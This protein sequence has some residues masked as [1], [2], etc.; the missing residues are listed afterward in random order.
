MIE[1][2]PVRPVRPLKPGQARCADAIGTDLMRSGRVL[3]RSKYRFERTMVPP[4]SC[5]ANSTRCPGG[6]IDSC[7]GL[8]GSLWVHMARLGDFSQSLCRPSQ[9]TT[10]GFAAVN[11]LQ[12][13]HV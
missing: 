10:I 6:G 9:Q 13:T 12:R 5:F 3:R 7:N 11:E 8:F 1:K 4:L 2:A